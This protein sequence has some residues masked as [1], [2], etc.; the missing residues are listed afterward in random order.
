M[1]SVDLE[2]LER[3]R[4]FR[5][6]IL[7][8]L[9]VALALAGFL[10]YAFWF[11]DEDG[12]GQAFHTHKVRTA[13]IRSTLTTSGIAE[14]ASETVLN[15]GI[16][17][18]VASV[19]VGLGDEVATGQ[20]LATL[21]SEDLQNAL[22]MA[23]ANLASARIR[24]QQLEQG[25]T[26][27]QIAAAGEAVQTAQAALDRAL[28]TQKDLLDGPDEAEIATAQDAVEGAQS[29]LLAA[30]DRLNDLQ[31]G[32]SDADLAAGESKVAT[33]E[34]SLATAESLYVSSKAGV[35][36]AEADLQS[37][38]TTYC[39]TE[40]HIRDICTP[41][42]IP[43]SPSAV[44]DL[45]QSIG[46]E[47]DESPS[48]ELVLATTALV[49][50]NSAYRRA[51]AARDEAKAGVNAAEAALQSAQEAL[52]ALKEPP[53]QADLDVAQAAVT[54]ANQTLEAA[55]LALDKLLAGPTE[56]DL[57]NAQSAVDS[58][59]ATL[60]AAIAA[61]DDVLAGAT[62]EEIDLQVQQLRLAELEVERASNA[63][64]DA[65]LIASFDGTV[66]AV[67]ISVGDVVS[68]SVPA[69]TL[70]TPDALRVELTLGETDLPPLK[71]GQTG[72]IIFD[73][74]QGVPFSITISKIGLAPETS[75]GVVTYSAEADLTD[76][77]SADVRPLPGMNGAAVIVTEERKDVL[78]VPARAIRR[79]GSSQ[80]V[81]VLVDGKPEIRVIQTGASDAENVEVINGLAEG[82][83]VVLLG[84][85][86]AAEEEEQEEE[87]NVIPEGI[88]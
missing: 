46:P 51:V 35:Q 60:S 38:G 15:F 20:K 2:A 79:Q 30:Q 50:A 37:A 12:N 83:L 42:S 78:A 47:A 41:F 32:P 6:I 18:R 24:L 27:A 69:I 68:A 64:D 7:A 66:A 31:E 29:A 39:D 81:E 16:P 49:G 87:E 8:V 86:P 82:D 65:I 76:L 62:Q 80:V 77:D 48:N 88:R 44:S 11:S 52:D 21:Q 17:G 74:I 73:A 70:L 14:A 55:Q 43:L 5:W 61:R 63:L 23:E 3:R 56:T 25:S 53:D 72:L 36:A 33:A 58:A 22:A 1:E 84:A 54:S 10:A 57:S 4:R 85:A 19:D 75:Q 9:L 59:R 28:N 71:I 13:T 26:D 40:D 45:S 67:N 34:A